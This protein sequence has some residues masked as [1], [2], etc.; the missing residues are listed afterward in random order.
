MDQFE[1]NFNTVKNISNIMGG[2]D[3]FNRLFDQ[4]LQKD[5]LGEKIFNENVRAY[6]DIDNMYV[7][8]KL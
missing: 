6:F 3:K 4:T 7:L 1:Q 5:W 2:G 8:K